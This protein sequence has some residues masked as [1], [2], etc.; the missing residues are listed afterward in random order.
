MILGDLLNHFRPWFPPMKVRILIADR[1]D[2]CREQIT[3]GKKVSKEWH[4]IL[5]V[6]NTCFHD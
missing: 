2:Y 4:D 1:Y 5:Y 6:L 3:S